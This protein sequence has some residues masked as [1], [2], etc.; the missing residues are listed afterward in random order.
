MTFPSSA[1]PSHLVKEVLHPGTG[2]LVT[3]GS[4][5]VVNY[6][7]QI[8]QGAVFD[9]SFSRH[10]AAAFT[11]GDGSVIPGWDKT[12]VGARV[13][14]RLLLVLPPNDGYGKTGNAAAGITGTDT[15]TF[16]VDLIATYGKHSTGDPHAAPVTK[17]HDGVTVNGGPG[18]MPTV[19]IAKNAPQPGS[20]SS[21]L[22]ARGHGASIQA[23]E[24]IFQ[25]AEFNWKGKAIASTWTKGGNPIAL[26]IGDAS[27]PGV[28]DALIGTPVGSRALI[29]IPA[30]S[31][32]GPSAVVIDVVGQT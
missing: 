27:Q 21:T 12:L 1:P 23:G 29:E 20:L 8:W 14:S 22:L 30:S 28:L 6:T 7:G 4:V 3:K 26:P 17:T 32:G 11:I 15:L 13:G 19:T 24:L 10:Q 5:I 18:A 16:V 9:S 2:A 31:Q 25:F